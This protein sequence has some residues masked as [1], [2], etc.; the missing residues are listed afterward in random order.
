[1]RIPGDF[2][3]AKWQRD[4]EHQSIEKL[5]APHMKDGRYFNPWMPVEH[6]TILKF[7]RWQLSKKTAYTDEEMNL[8]PNILPH[9]KA[10]I[11]SMPNEE[12][13]AW[14]GH[15]TFLMRLGGEYWLTDPMFSDRALLP[16]RV[17]PPAL[18][19]DELRKITDRLNVVISHN[20]YDHLDA[21]SIRSLPEKSRFFVPLGLKKYIES[22]HGGVVEELDWWQ[23]VALENGTR[24]QCLPAQH[25]SRR[26]G[27]G[28]N[29]TLWASYM[30]ITPQTSIYYGGDSGYFVGYREFKKRFS[31]ITYAL[32][33]VTAYHPRW[34]MHYNHMNAP[35]ALRAFMDLGARYIIPTQWGAFGL[36]DNPPG[37]PALDLIKTIKKTNLDPSRVLIMDIG[38]IEVIRTS[39]SGPTAP[40]RPGTE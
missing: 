34:V 38:Q 24:L 30:L 10:R 32:L 27:Q 1:M 20:H 23:E 31:D 36:G 6:G 26:I 19:A 33:P 9:L 17:T 29:S 5:Y 14:I 40:E 4:V 18:S 16:K 3:E 21:D 35:E 39:T 37:L 7:L 25:W 12:F 22:L 11:V 28:T 13:I 8:R 15:S 2:D